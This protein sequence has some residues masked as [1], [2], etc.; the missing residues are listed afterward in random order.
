MNYEEQF[1][2]SIVLK[3]SQ[4]KILDGIKPER[5]I[6]TNLACFYN[7]HKQIHLVEKPMPVAGPGQVVVHVCRIPFFDRL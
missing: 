7:Q 2:P 1:D 4:F 3:S 5:N 6:Q